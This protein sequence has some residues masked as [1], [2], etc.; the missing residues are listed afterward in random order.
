[1]L[2]IFSIVNFINFAGIVKGVQ[3]F[4]RKN[5][6][7]GSLYIMW[8]GFL[9]KNRP[10]LFWGQKFRTKRLFKTSKEEI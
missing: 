8:I 10:K 9:Q 4:H 7:T 6:F 1:M 2:F 5:I 3:L